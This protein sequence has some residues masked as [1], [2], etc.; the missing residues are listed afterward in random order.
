VEE[1]F[2]MKKIA[3]QILML[4]M[5]TAVSLDSFSVLLDQTASFGMEM[6]IP[7]ESEPVQENNRGEHIESETEEDIFHTFNTRSSNNQKDSGAVA[8]YSVHNSTAFKEIVL[9]PPI[10]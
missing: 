9:P 6:S 5:V 8:N 3:V 2:S 1:N 4:V 7:L 10:R